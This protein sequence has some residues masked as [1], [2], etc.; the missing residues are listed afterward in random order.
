MKQLGRDFDSGGEFKD[1]DSWYKVRPKDSFEPQEKVSRSWKK[2]SSRNFSQKW[3]NK[4]IFLSW[5]LGNTFLGEVTAWQ[6]RF[7]IY[8]PL[9]RSNIL[10]FHFEGTEF[11]TL[12]LSQEMAPKYLPIWG[13]CSNRLVSEI[14]EERYEKRKIIWRWRDLNWDHWGCS[15]EC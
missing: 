14:N 9:V 13:K 15:W 6:F 5:W 2:L 12:T 10:L 8:W 11:E 3:T 7:K 4:F 1:L